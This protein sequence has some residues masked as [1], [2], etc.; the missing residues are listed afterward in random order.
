MQKDMIQYLKC[1]ICK[2]FFNAAMS[3][4]CS[5]T[6]CSQ[7]IRVHLSSKSNCP[8]CIKDVKGIFELRNDRLLDSI[9][10]VVTK[11]NQNVNS[12]MED[13]NKEPDG[14]VCTFKIIDDE[15]VQ[16]PICDK[17]VIFRDLNSHMDFGCK[18]GSTNNFFKRKSLKKRSFKPSV[19]YSCYN[20]KEL[21]KL[22]SSD[23]LSS[24]GDRH[25]LIKRHTEF[26]NIHNSN[27]DRL[28]PHPQE[29]VISQVEE[30]ERNCKIYI[31]ISSVG[32]ISSFKKSFAKI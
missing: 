15:P 20:D 10:D 21:R 11:N 14:N 25:S 18:S 12:K 16:C 9:V 27:L 28:D 8:T 24:N 2:D 5:H 29:W 19:P 6:F 1:S 32:Q 23:G 26:L 17:Y 7:C 30:W 13:S 31:L 3:L 22:V 4:S